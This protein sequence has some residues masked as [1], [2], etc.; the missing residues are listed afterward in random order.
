[1]YRDD[2]GDLKH[3]YE[4]PRRRPADYWFP[5]DPSWCVASDVDLCWTYVGGTQRCIEA[6]LSCAD[7]E[8]CRWTWTKDPPSIR[9][10]SIG[11]RPKKSLAGVDRHRSVHR[12]SLLA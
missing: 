9:I 11:F 7:L 3:F 8:P 1:M 5:Q 6:I 10:S 4:W 2:L 12:S